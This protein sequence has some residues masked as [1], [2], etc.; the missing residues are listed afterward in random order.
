MTDESPRIFREVYSDFLD[1]KN[2]IIKNQPFSDYFVNVKHEKVILGVLNALG[3]KSSAMSVFYLVLTSK[4][5]NPKE[6]GYFVVMSEI[7]NLRRNK[8]GKIELE[9]AL[10]LQ[11]LSVKL[12]NVPPMIAKSQ[13]YRFNEEEYD[14]LERAYKEIV[15]WI[16]KKIN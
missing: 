11:Y 1:I 8:N 3:H 13:L 10:V 14:E 9:I 6:Y 4:T 15:A 16:A 5:R 2:K 7:K 12:E